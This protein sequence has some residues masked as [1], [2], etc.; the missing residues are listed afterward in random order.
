[1]NKKVTFIL[2]STILCAPAAHGMDAMRTFASTIGDYVSKHP[3]KA[4]AVA[5]VG[6]GMLTAVVN[7][8]AKGFPATKAVKRKTVDAAKHVLDRTVASGKTIAQTA[9]DHKIPAILAGAAAG[10]LVGEEIVSK[11]TVFHFIKD[12]IV[13]SATAAGNGTWSVI[14]HPVESTQ[15][16]LKGL[17]SLTKSSWKGIKFLYDKATG[18][19][20]SAKEF[21]K[22]YPTIP[23]TVAKTAAAATLAGGAFLL[24]R[25]TAPSIVPAPVA[26]PSEEGSEQDDE[27]E[28]IDS[29]QETIIEDLAAPVEQDVVEGI[30]I[31]RTAEIEV[32]TDPI[33]EEAPADASTS[34]AQPAPVEQD[35]EETQSPTTAEIEVQTDPIEEEAPADVSTSVAQPAPVEQ[36]AEEAQSPRTAEIEV[37]TDPVEEEAP[38]VVSAPAP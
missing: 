5:A 20:E 25:A 36:D 1:M 35:A 6:T 3:Y 13:H 38:A 34:V 22:A 31:P 7:E 33:E 4:G 28:V 23:K 12:G 11:G 10:A 26:S 17:G 18:L 24:G 16:V 9:K 2:L 30:Q 19:G 14:Q 32:Q 29:E 8:S 15:T 21:A 27:S 37:Q